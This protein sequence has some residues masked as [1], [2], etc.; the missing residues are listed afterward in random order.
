M[1]RYHIDRAKHVVDLA[2]AIPTVR[3]ICFVPGEYMFQQRLL[4]PKLEWEQVIVAATQEVGRHAAERGLDLAIEL[5]PFP[6][7]FVNSMDADGP[8]PM[9]IDLWRTSRPPLTSPTSG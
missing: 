9:P 6:F 4:P 8:V 7:A 3:N 1:R 2:A 5:L